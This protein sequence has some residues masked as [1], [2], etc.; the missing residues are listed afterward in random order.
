MERIF[1][2]GKDTPEFDTSS[3][4][5]WSADSLQTQGT[6]DKRQLL[7][8]LEVPLHSGH[9]TAWK[10]S[11]ACITDTNQRMTASS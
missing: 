8:L 4:G 6:P 3:L 7:C 2:P 11:T 5:S 10:A 9:V 1:Q